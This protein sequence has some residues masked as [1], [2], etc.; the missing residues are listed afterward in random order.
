MASRSEIALR[1]SR[2]QLETAGHPWIIWMLHAKCVHLIRQA[3]ATRPHEGAHRK[4][5]LTH[6]QN[7][8]AELEGSLKVTDELSK[9]LFY[10]YDY[11]YCLL[12]TEVP[13]DHALALKVLSVL[14]DT[15]AALLH[16]R[17]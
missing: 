7:L 12:D 6:A 16:K 8:L 11:C 10:L 15:F 9:G 3:Q 1:Y 13:E 4:N 17:T 5:L 14:R 2:T